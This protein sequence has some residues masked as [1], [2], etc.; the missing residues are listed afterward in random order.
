MHD[1]VIN[2]S[3]ESWQEPTCAVNRFLVTPG[4]LSDT[5]LALDLAFFPNRRRRLMAF[6]ETMVD[7]LDG[8]LFTR[9]NR[10]SRTRRIYT[11]LPGI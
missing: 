9:I 4:I 3:L 7:A 6:Q 1:F 10:R 11:I 2:I 8:Y 5:C